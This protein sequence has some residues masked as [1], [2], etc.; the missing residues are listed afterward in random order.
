[1]DNSKH[2]KDS[3]MESSLQVNSGVKVL[4]PHFVIFK[5]DEEFHNKLD[6]L[7][8]AAKNGVPLEFKSRKEACLVQNLLGGKVFTSV[9]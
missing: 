1:M 8:N 3:V 5:D 9:A 4:R 2:I 6:Q 7:T